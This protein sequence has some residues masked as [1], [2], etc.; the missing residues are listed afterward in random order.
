MCLLIITVMNSTRSTQ[1]AQTSLAEADQYSHMPT[2]K[3]LSLGGERLTAPP[4][5]PKKKKKTR[6]GVWII[7][8]TTIWFSYRYYGVLCSFTHLRIGI[9]YCSSTFGT[10]LIKRFRC[11]V[12]LLLV[13][14]LLKDSDYIG[15]FY[16]FSTFGTILNIIILLSFRKLNCW[17]SP[18]RLLHLQP[19]NFTH[20]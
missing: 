6:K 19:P 15:I 3:M 20:R 12:F 11:F 7:T 5:P 9:F 17:L 14:S 8:C 2:V 18:Q 1:R 13:I 4:P 16:C 10:I